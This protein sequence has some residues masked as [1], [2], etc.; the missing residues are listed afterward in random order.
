MMSCHSLAINFTANAPN[1]FTLFLT[2]L[3]IINLRLQLDL[4]GQWAN[5]LPQHWRNIYDW[6][7]LP[8]TIAP[9]LFWKA[10][11]PST[12]VEDFQWGNKCGSFVFWTSLFTFYTWRYQ[13]PFTTWVCLCVCTTFLNNGIPLPHCRNGSMYLNQSVLTPLDSL[14]VLR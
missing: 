12:T 6:N 1:I 9:I 7:S 14:S 4:S 13:D 8:S 2:S 11:T 5:V 10:Y 3:A